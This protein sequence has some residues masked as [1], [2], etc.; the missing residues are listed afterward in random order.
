MDLVLVSYHALRQPKTPNNPTM[1]EQIENAKASK[2]MYEQKTA[3]GTT[4][5]TTSNLD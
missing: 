2:G 1:Q 3:K 4:S 5:R